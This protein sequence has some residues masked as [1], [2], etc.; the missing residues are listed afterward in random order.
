LTGTVSL[1]EFV[2]ATLNIQKI[3]ETEEG[4]DILKSVF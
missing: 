3:C 4:E 2:C 1:T